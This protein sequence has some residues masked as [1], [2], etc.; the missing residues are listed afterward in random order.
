MGEM[1]PRLSASLQNKEDTQRKRRQVFP[2]A[3]YESVY[4]GYGDI[5][6]IPCM[7]F[8]IHDGLAEFQKTKLHTV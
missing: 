4:Y 8:I 7:L 1:F 5:A 2:A 6:C 3:A